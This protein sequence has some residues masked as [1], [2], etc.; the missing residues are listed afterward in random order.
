MAVPVAT[1]AYFKMNERD[2]DKAKARTSLEGTG[3]WRDTARGRGR[4]YDS[5]AE[6]INFNFITIHPHAN[7]IRH[8]DTDCRICSKTSEMSVRVR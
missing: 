6:A 5:F 7:K 2:Q 8:K 3:K 4:H 1:A